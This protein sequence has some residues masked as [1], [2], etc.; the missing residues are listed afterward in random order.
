MG[1]IRVMIRY[2]QRVAHGNEWETRRATM[3]VDETV[4]VD[5]V[6]TSWQREHPDVDWDTIT[7]TRVEAGT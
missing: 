2:T 1:M 5:P 7:V 4:G 6:L 3:N